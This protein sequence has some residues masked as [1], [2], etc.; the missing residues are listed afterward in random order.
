MKNDI[1]T[2]V[3]SVDV[4]FDHV[5]SSEKNIICEKMNIL[6]DISKIVFKSVK[7]YSEPKIVW[8]VSDDELILK[9]FDT[10]KNEIISKKDEIGLHCLISKFLDVNNVKISDLEKY[11]KESITKLNEYGINPHSS[12]MMGCTA[13][14]ELLRV[15]SK[16][17]IKVDSSA[18]PGRKRDIS[19]SFDWS[20]TLTKPYFP[21]IK[22]Y[23]ITSEKN[24]NILQVPL[25]VI[26]TKTPYD[27]HPILRYFDLSFKKEIIELSLEN[28]IKNNNC[29]ISIIHPE[30]LLKSNK[31]NQL[32][33]NNID[34]FE[35][36]IA[37]FFDIAEA[38]GKK[39]EC[40][41]FNDI[42]SDSKFH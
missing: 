4:Y 30:Q 39:I 12:R 42:I 1:I 8:L 35:Q 38:L 14:N 32:Y 31:P 26:L 36:N 19:I 28:L 37:K 34:D 13:N 16:N 41:S 33:A 7:S 24:L 40:I 17:G 29:I 20:T 3:L 21:S 5:L 9:K 22:D 2:L 10:I 18:I 27:K 25:S 6:K 23:R 11:L 15:L